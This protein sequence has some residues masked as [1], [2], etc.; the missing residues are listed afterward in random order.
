M[1]RGTR[2]GRDRGVV[3]R[4]GESEAGLVLD[5]F[6]AAPDRLG[7]RSRALAAR[8]RG[9]VFL[10]GVEAGAARASPNGRLPQGAMPRAPSTVALLSNG[11]LAA[12]A[13]CQVSSV[14]M[15]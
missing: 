13:T 14:T 5:K 8:E 3:W 2:D 15:S 10:N 9:K 7:S 6:L 1:T 4:V 12:G 11:P